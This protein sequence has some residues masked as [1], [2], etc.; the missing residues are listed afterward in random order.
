MHRALCVCDLVAPLELATRLVLVMHRREVSKTTATGRLALNVLPNSELH[1]HGRPDVRVDLTPLHQQDRRV[2]LLYPGEGARPLTQEL[3]DDDPRPVTLIVPDGSWGQAKRAAKRIPGMA[4]AELVV[5]PAGSPTAYRLREEPKLGGLA[6]FEAIARALGVLESPA[7]QEQLEELF[8][9]M[10]ERTLSTRALP[11]AVT[12][13]AAEIQAHPPLEIIYRDNDLV[14]VNKPAGMP[15]HRGWARDGIP[16]LQVL[17]EQIGCTVHPVHRLDRPTSGVLLFATSSEMHRLVQKQ[18]N[19]HSVDKRY[20]ALCRG[21]D[22][23][24]MQVDHPLAKREDL[25]PRPAVTDF[26]LLGQ[27]ERYGL[28]EARPRTG[29]LHQIRRHLKH[30]SHPIIGDVRY[31]KGEHNRLFRTRFGFHRLALH[32]ASLTLTHPKTQEPLTL[33]APLPADFSQL[34]QTLQLSETVS[35]RER[36]PTGSSG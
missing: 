6:T 34:L 5:L 23:T 22:E 8:A 3:L 16:A 30:A 28:F 35:E 26:R 4:Q 31:G 20:L 21:H 1:I 25:E 29:R 27:F 17:R 33:Q 10:V 7:I 19:E 11:G 9:T 2:L 12:L 24:L 36:S 32:A 18:F 15:V 14:A 13:T